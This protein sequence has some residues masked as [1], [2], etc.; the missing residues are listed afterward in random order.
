MASPNDGSTSQSVP[1]ATPAPQG[2]STTETNTSLKQAGG[3]TTAPDAKL[4]VLSNI[5]PIM[6]SYLKVIA[7]ET[8]SIEHD[9]LSEFENLHIATPKESRET[10][11][12]VAKGAHSTPP[13]HKPAASSHILDFSTFL[14]YMTSPSSNALGPLPEAELDVLDYP[15]AS[16]FISSS[17]NTYLTGNQLYSESSTGA[18][19]NVLLRGCRCIEIDVWDGEEKSPPSS[20]DEEEGKTAAEARKAKDGKKG[21]LRSHLPSAIS[22][23]LHRSRSRGP[24]APPEPAT[25]AKESEESQP[26]SP[27]ISQSTALRAE[28]RV[29]HGYTMTKEVP[30]RDVCEAIRRYAFATSELP[31]IVSLEIH[32]GPA[33]QEIMVEIMEQVWRGMLVKPL[34][35]ETDQWPSPASLRKKIL[36]KVKHVGG[37]KASTERKSKQAESRSPSSSQ[38][39]SEGEDR[40]KNKKKEKGKIIE[41]L[42]ALGVYTC[43]YSFKGLSKPEATLPHHVFSLSEKKL[44]EVHESSGPTLFSHNRNFLMRAFPSG[45]RI[46]SSNLDP[47]LYWRKGVQMVALNWQKWDAGMMLNE[48]MFAGSQGWVLKPRGYRSTGRTPDAIGHESQAT[49]SP[50]RVLDLIVEIFAAQGLPL[51]EGDTRPDHF[52]PYVKCELHVEQ[53]EERSGAPIEGSS[54][55]RGGQHKRKSKASRGVDPSFAREKMEFS[56]IAGVVEELSFVR[57]KIQDEKDFGKDALAAWACLRLDRL[58]TG[59]RF[60][61]LLDANGLES[62][63]VLLVKITKQL[64]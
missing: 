61:H 11:S 39:S 5:S 48:G 51:P 2:L 64:T 21:G 30:F 24:K 25:M 60:I 13:S 53:S 38:P 44:M 4:N 32:T 54:K 3:G 1:S 56:S 14:N 31:L 33:Q 59:H 34:S 20:S 19:V 17:H 45:T 52:R 58:R 15:L 37:T 47:S 35:D 8:S 16:Y 57:F 49:A 23:R 27:W 29:L 50:H 63:G 62:R 41:P 42:G 6:L 10:K 40:T 43:S 46:S 36:V 55:A 18:Y 12:A 22:S 9:Q 28:P 26:P 7:A